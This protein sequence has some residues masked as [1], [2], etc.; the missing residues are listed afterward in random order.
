MKLVLALCLLAVCFYCVT[1]LSPMRCT[2]ECD[3]SKCYQGDKPCKCNSF[4][5]ECNCCDRC[6]KCPGEPCSPAT[7]QICGEGTTCKPTEGNEGTSL[8]LRPGTCQ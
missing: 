8:W 1:S 7:W 2:G 5:D 3:R 6:Y 4:K